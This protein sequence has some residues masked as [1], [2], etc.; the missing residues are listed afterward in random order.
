M[1]PAMDLSA[2]TFE[3]LSK[4]FRKNTKQWSKAD[5]HAQ[6]IRHTDSS[7]MDM[8]DTS[9][10][11][12]VNIFLPCE[13]HAN[14][15]A[16]SSGVNVQAKLLSEERKDASAHGQT[17]WIVSGIKIQEQQCVHAH[18]SLLSCS[19]HFK[20]GYQILTSD[21]WIHTHPRGGPSY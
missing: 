7:I 3:S 16:A 14:G 20:I 5:Q 18:P 15:W 13:L 8:H 1:E 2:E 11:K 6:L 4:Q 17:S 10:A 9:T 21:A 12:G 19:H